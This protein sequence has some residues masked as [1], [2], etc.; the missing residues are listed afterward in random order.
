[1]T[2]VRKALNRNFLFLI[3]KE[4][5][6]IQHHR[7]VK[8]V[9]GSGLHHSDGLGVAAWVNV[10]GSSFVLS[11]RSKHKQLVRDPKTP[12]LRTVGKHN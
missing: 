6:T 3:V 12:Y 4:L 9:L 10:E 11:V 2:V 1:M 7:A 5:C 8:Y